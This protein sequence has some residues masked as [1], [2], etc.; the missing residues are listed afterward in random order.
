MR[1]KAILGVV[2]LVAGIAARAPAQTQGEF[3][4]PSPKQPASRVGTR[5]AN[6]LQIGV[7]AQALAMAG[8]Y[9]GL[10]TGATSMYWN[11][12]GLGSVTTFSAA[13]TR[14]DLYAGL[15]ITHTFAGLV[16]PFLGGGLG[17]SFIQLSSGDIPRT[18]V[19]DPDGGDPATG[20]VFSWNGTAVGVHYGRRLTDRLSVG[21]AGKA[22]SEGLNDANATWWGLD[23]GTQFNTGLYGLSIGATLSN[24]GPSA[25]MEGPLIE[26]R[27]QDTDVFP[28]Q[29]PVRFNTTPAQLPTVFRFSLI[30]NLLGSSDALLSPSANNRLHGVLEF[31]DGVDTDL[32]TAIAAEYSYRNILFL[33]A[34]KR[35]MGEAQTDFREGS[36]GFSFGGGVKIPLFGRRVSFDYA[37]TTLTDLDNVQVFSFEFGGN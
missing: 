35:W 30:S 25:R 23:V 33:R 24:I 2:A 8:A 16:I 34:G 4:T 21:A 32:Q 15:D 31:S 19:T 3:I 10:A 29:V 28:V 26:R 36:H 17:L 14:A 9:T 6:F 7:G 11:S 1:R 27:I 37:Y 12:A 18:T 13:F 22:I 20:R 5:G